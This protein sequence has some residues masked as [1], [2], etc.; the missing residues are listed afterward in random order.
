MQKW[1]SAILE[2]VGTPLSLTVWASDDGI[3]RRRDQDREGE[4]PPLARLAWS[5]HPGPASVNFADESLEISENGPTQADTTVTFT[6]PD[7]YLLRVLATDR[8]GGGGSQC[9]WTNAF[10][11]VNVS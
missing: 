9:R 1:P 3:R 6:G 5:L 4:P 11:R 7:E 2:V 8:S 10:V